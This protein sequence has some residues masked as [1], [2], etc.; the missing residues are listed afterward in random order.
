MPVGSL[1]LV[2]MK[3][4][5]NHSERNNFEPHDLGYELPSPKH[6]APFESAL[7]FAEPLSFSLA[8]GRVGSI[9][10]PF[11]KFPLGLCR[12]FSSGKGSPILDF[13]PWFG[14]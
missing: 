6:M 8:W 7:A 12:G 3:V 13:S 2:L 14:P 1:T 9:G 5:K 11:Y 10:L 4:S